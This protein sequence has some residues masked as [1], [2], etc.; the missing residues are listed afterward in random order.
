[1]QNKLFEIEPQHPTKFCRTCEHRERHS[2][3]NKV[4]QYCGIVK[5][6]LTDSGQLKIKCKTPACQFYKEIQQ[7]TVT[8]D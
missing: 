3:G 1:M 8:K 7:V 5:S 2:C 6:N 4:I